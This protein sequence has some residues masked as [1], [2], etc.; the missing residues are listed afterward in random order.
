MFSDLL[1]ENC[2]LIHKT[3]ISLTKIER[4]KRKLCRYWNAFAL[5][6][7][8]PLWRKTKLRDFV[9]VLAQMQLFFWL[10]YRRKLIC[11]KN[12]SA[13]FMMKNIWAK[14]FVYDQWWARANSADCITHYFG[15]HEIIFRFNEKHFC[16]LFSDF[17]SLYWTKI[18]TGLQITIEF[19]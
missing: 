19:N 1:Q 6:S 14:P 3:F 17:L 11:T 8:C 10:R 16:C 15:C 7:L 4:E 2:R 9:P 12:E 5:D 13:I 18:E